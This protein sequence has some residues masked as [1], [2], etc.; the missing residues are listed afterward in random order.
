MT[1]LPQGWI[2]KEMTD[3]VNDLSNQA[4]L[5]SSWATDAALADRQNTIE[6]L[7]SSILKFEGAENTPVALRQ[8]EVEILQVFFDSRSAFH[9]TQEGID[10]LPYLLGV[11]GRAHIDLADK[12]GHEGAAVDFAKFFD[13]LTQEFPRMEKE[14]R[15]DFAESLAAFSVTHPGVDKDS[16]IT[17][18]IALKSGVESSF[19]LEPSEQLNIVK[20]LVFLS[21]QYGKFHA[22]LNSFLSHNEVCAR[23]LPGMTTQNRAEF[24]LELLG[25]QRAIQSQL[26]K[27]ECNESGD[28]A[29][30]KEALAKELKKE[31]N[32][33]F[34]MNDPDL[35]ALAGKI[36]Q[37]MEKGATTAQVARWIAVDCAIELRAVISKSGRLPSRND[38]DLARQALFLLQKNNKFPMAVNALHTQ[39]SEAQNPDLEGVMKKVLPFFAISS[40]LTAE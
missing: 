26:G 37:M 34:F 10:F 9:S 40:R 39:L 32:F 5:A 20:Q 24:V 36:D 27:I 14:D 6:E 13:Q 33:E 28:F 15:L 16:L 23:R 3:T 35:Q 30:K 12:S 22:V 4:Y 18:F 19:N 29:L 25:L 38:A 2:P 1:W 8:K 17:S 21:P 11:Q 31:R 7:A